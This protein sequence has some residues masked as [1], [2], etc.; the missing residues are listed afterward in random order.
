M[1]EIMTKI[2]GIKGI[3]IVEDMMEEQEK[4]QV[5][6]GKK[7]KVKIVGEP[8][9]HWNFLCV[10]FFGKI[11]NLFKVGIEFYKEKLKF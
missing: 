11:A 10:K 2:L 5:E 3:R 8:F 9:L 6:E 1:G 7:K 4:N